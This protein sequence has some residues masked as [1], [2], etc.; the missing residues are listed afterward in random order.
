MA[1][2]R[3]VAAAARA[4]GLIDSEVAQLAD[5]FYRT[6]LR[7]Y[8]STLRDLADRFTRNGAPKTIPLSDQ[9]KEAL[10]A[11]AEANAR[12]V[13]DTHN[14]AVASEAMKIASPGDGRDRAGLERDLSVFGKKR[15]KERAEMIAVTEAYGPHADAIVSFFRDAGV[16]P[17]FEFGGHPEDAPP[18]CVICQSIIAANPHSIEDVVT[19][20]LPHP[21]CRQTWHPLFNPGDLPEDFN[22]GETLGGIIGQPTLIQREGGKQQAADAVVALRG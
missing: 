1:R 3:D 9:V 4:A 5:R 12:K 13:A 7:V 15:M 16:D 22:L 18:V 17:I 10:R 19:I 11:E 20:G 6:K 14:S 8:R 2:R 21:F